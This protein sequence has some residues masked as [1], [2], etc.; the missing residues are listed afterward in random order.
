MAGVAVPSTCKL[1][2]IGSV[3]S[4]EVV[5]VLHYKYTGASQTGA[6]LD[7]F[8]TAWRT[9]HMAQWLAVHGSGYVL[10]TII[11]TDISSLTGATATQFLTTGNVGT[12]GAACPPN[13]VAIA[14][15]WRTGL[16]G[17]RNRGRTFLGG[18]SSNQFSGDVVTGGGVSAI[19]TLA[20][21]LIAQTFTGGY[22]FGVTSLKDV[23]TKVITG[24]ILE[25]ILDSQRRRLPGRGS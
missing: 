23:L 22:D 17:R 2:L 9:A 19:G 6:Q 16:V 14:V 12:G 10:N 11:A 8:I 4:Q 24:A 21:A 1:E 25:T 5:N 18:L 7:A 13:N 20:T 15:S 3:D